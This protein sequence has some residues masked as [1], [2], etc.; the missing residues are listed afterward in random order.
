[1]KKLF[2][3]MLRDPECFMYKI[4]HHSQTVHIH[5]CHFP[6]FIELHQR[7]VNIVTSSYMQIG[8][9]VQSLTDL[10][11]VQNDSSLLEMRSTFVK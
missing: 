11:S 7:Q 10:T 3:N 5:V 1:M 4:K 6:P 8:Q 9:F 2:Y